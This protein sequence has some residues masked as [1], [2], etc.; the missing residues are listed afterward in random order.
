MGEENKY[1]FM[2][3]NKSTYLSAHK[4]VMRKM[5]RILPKRAQEEQHVQGQ[6]VL[7]SS[8]TQENIKW[9]VLH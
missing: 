5:V 4:Y 3:M 7:I 8:S 2:D 6:E 9:S 1:I